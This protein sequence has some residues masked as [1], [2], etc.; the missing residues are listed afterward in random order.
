MLVAVD[1]MAAAGGSVVSAALGDGV[2]EGCGAA[3]GAVVGVGDGVLQEARKMTAAIRKMNCFIH[4][5]QSGCS[6]ISFRAVPKRSAS[7]GPIG[8]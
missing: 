1:R 8:G 3:V 2:T 7:W 4:T 5:V 6:T